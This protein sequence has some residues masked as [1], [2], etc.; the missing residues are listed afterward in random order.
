LPNTNANYH[1][2]FQAWQFKTK[3]SQATFFFSYYNSKNVTK[4]IGN[5][6]LGIKSQT[7]VKIFL[8]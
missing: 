3:F 8:V 4:N 7:I 6:P 1:F 2:F 5:L